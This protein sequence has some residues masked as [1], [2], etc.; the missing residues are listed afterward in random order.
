MHLKITNQMLLDRF[1]IYCGANKGWLPPCYGTKNY[2]EMSAEEQT[3][4]DSFHGDSTPG[5]GQKGYEHVLAR[6]GYFLAPP[7]HQTAALPDTIPA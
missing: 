3:V 6:A 4:V 1:N 5:S 2:Q 7:N